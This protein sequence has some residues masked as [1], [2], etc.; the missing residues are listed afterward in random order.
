MA[1]LAAAQMSN[2]SEFHAA[3]PAYEI[4]CSPIGSQPW[5]HVL[6]AEADR[7]PACVADVFEIRRASARV[8][9][10]RDCAQFEVNMIAYRQPV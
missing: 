7:R 2:G 8:Y 5:R 1:G 6:A 9:S 4:A 3:G 10:V